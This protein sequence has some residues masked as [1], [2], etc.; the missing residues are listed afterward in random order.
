VSEIG[1]EV[2]RMR[3]ENL[4]CVEIR[5]ISP[6]VVC[7]GGS[8]PVVWRGKVAVIALISGGYICFSNALRG[9]GEGG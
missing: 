3:R 7:Q 8:K 2:S 1:S 4:T 9:K 6:D 5:R